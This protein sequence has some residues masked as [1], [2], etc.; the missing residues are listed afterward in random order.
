[1]KRVWLIIM[2]ILAL[3]FGGTSIVHASE[4]QVITEVDLPVN[5][6]ELYLN[7]NIQSPILY[8]TLVCSVNGAD[9]EITGFT[10]TSQ[11]YKADTAGTYTFTATPP[12]GYAFAEGVTPTITVRVRPATGFASPS[13]RSYY[14]PSSYATGISYDNN[15][16]GLYATVAMGSDN[17][18]YVMDVLG[19]NKIYVI[20][21]DTP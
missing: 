4:S 16:T 8:D 11:D 5:Y 20:I 6:T 15:I 1:M 19:K 21:Q 7:L 3:L 14:Y 12:E 2:C 9:V 18:R 13:E 17:K 10:W